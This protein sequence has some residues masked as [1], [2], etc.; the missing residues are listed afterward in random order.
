MTNKFCNCIDQETIV[1]STVGRF[2]Y[3]QTRCRNCGR[4][5]TKKEE[6]FDEN[7]WMEM[8]KNKSSNK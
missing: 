7:S 3:T 4:M 5:F 1:A 6:L 2:L 8:I